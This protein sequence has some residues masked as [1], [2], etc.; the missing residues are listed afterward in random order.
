MDLLYL[1]KTNKDVFWRHS[2]GEGLIATVVNE[3]DGK[4]LNSMRAAMVFSGGETGD[5]E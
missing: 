3:L 4:I 5:I 1:P 2:V